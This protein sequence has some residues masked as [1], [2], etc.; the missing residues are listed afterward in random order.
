MERYIFGILFLI[1]GVLLTA[2]NR[3]VWVDIKRGKVRGV[4]G[5]LLIILGILLLTG[6]LPMG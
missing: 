4:A 3:R 2:R 6:V 1:A 5:P